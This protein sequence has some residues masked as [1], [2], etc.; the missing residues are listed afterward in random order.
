MYFFFMGLSTWEDLWTSFLV[1]ITF[2]LLPIL[3]THYKMRKHNA[4]VKELLNPDTPGGLG[5]ISGNGHN[6]KSSE[7][8][9]SGS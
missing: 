4:E 3:Y 7:P 1:T 9:D 8:L 6:E 5:E 2:A